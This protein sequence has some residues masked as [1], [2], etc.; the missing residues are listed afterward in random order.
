MVDS[1]TKHGF[2]IKLNKDIQSRPSRRRSRIHITY[3][4][5]YDRLSSQ[6]RNIKAVDA[7]KAEVK[8]KIMNES[9]NFCAISPLI[10]I[11]LFCDSV[12]DIFLL[13]FNLIFV[14]FYL[15]VFIF[16]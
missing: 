8:L 1:L 10:A 3:D 4:H 16:D 13:A 9:K 6:I 15:F 5:P 11:N 14:C 12:C 2:D 7:F